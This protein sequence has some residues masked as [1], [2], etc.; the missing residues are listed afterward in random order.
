MLETRPRQDRLEAPAQALD[1]AA[2]LERVMGDRAMHL[3]V[4]GRFRTDYRD[5]IPRLRQALL[6]GDTVLAQRITHTLKGAAAMIEA[7]RLR[8]LALDTEHAV[9]AQGGAGAVP[10]GELEAELARV[11]A[12]VDAA[13]A[14]PHAATGLHGGGAASNGELASLRAM[15]DLGDGAA[16]ALLEARRGAFL[17]TLGAERMRRLDAAVSSFDFEQ[18]L[19]V[20]EEK[21]GN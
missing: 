16:P 6:A 13:L 10:T 19:A 20:L 5:T 21:G 11:L 4:L 2:G 15:L 17:A 8:Q 1:L 18:A 14:A 7:R 12:E 9:R 3:R